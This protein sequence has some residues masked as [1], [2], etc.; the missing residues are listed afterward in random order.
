MSADRRGENFEPKF[1]KDFLSELL[2]GEFMVVD[3]VSEV[4]EEASWKF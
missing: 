1:H 4:G 3:D 2:L